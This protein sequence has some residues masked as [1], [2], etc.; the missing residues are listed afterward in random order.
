M[1]GKIIPTG[2]DI[3][4]NPHADAFDPVAWY[5]GTGEDL[6][7]PAD[8]FDVPAKRHLAGK[9]DQKAHGHGGGVSGSGTKDD[10]IRTR[11]VTVA[12][13]ALAEGKYVE[14]AH[15]RQ[16]STLLD[17]LKADV[18]DAVAK[19]EKAPEYDLCKVSV[20]K[21]NL[22]CQQSKGIP[23]AEMPQLKG[24]PDPGTP[25]D[26]LPKNQKGEVDLSAGFRDYM[27]AKGYAVSPD[28]ID[29]EY[30]KA[31]QNQLEGAKVVGIASAMRAGRIPEE[32]IFVSNDDYI[33]DGHHRWAA[34]VANEYI[35]GKPLSMPVNVIDA[36]IITILRE[37]ND[38]AT[39]MG[40][41]QA[42][43]GVEGRSAP[44]RP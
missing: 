5:E 16:V 21:T 4:A 20:P 38:Y 36:P 24:R 39:T 13:K 15:E 12:Q 26:Y 11:D 22:F 19:G 42:A 10:P 31:S 17:K 2:Y 27:T 14:L 35:Q 9:H 23:R 40:I 37:A 1:T 33:V 18:D 6:G 29:A 30:L 41:P 8:Y 3:E 32:S 34:T 28:R 43:F 25:A 44:R 7:L